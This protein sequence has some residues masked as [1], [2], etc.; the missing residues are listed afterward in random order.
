MFNFHTHTNQNNAICNIDRLDFKLNKNHYYS[1]GNHPWTNLFTS[2]SLNS[3]LIKNNQIIA[4]GECGIDKVK[5]NKNL[6]QQLKILK[7]QIIL[8]EKFEIP[9]I[10][11][12]VKSFNEIIKLKKDLNPKQKWIIHGFNNYK[13]TDILL[14]NDFYLSFGTAIL[15]NQKLQNQLKTIPLKYIFIETDDSNIEIEKL[16]TYVAKIKGISCLKLI[17]QINQNLTI[18]TNGKLARTF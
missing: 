3:F 8:S 4:I 18:I 14:E 2:K 7:D 17:K 11:H 5:S 16:Y 6:V 15:T 1:I 10:L 12:I 9:L 13:H